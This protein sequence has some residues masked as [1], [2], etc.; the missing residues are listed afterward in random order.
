MK[1]EEK[2]RIHYREARNTDAPAPDWLV[3]MMVLYGEMIQSECS[4]VV[5]DIGLKY[6]EK[7]YAQEENVADECEAA[8]LELYK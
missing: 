8:I 1:L 2:S 3:K 5:Y 6:R 4:G 7:H